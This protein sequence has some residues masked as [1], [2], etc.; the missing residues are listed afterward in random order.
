M[1]LHPGPWYASQVSLTAHEPRLTRTFRKLE[2][3]LFQSLDPNNRPNSFDES[4]LIQLPIVVGYIPSIPWGLPFRV[5]IHSWETPRLFRPLPQTAH[6]DVIS[7][8]EAR[9]VVDG[10]CVACVLQLLRTNC[11]L[12]HILD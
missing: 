3:A 4:S 10:C 8:F 9:V 1:S 5:S 6:Q 2:H 12:A 7:L 11:G